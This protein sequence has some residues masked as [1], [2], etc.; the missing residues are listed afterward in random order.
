MLLKKHFWLLSML[1]TVNIFMKPW[2]ILFF[3]IHR[4]IESSKEQRLFEIEIFCNIINVFT[5][6]FDHFNASLLN[7]SIN[8][9][10]TPNIQTYVYTVYCDCND[11]CDDVFPQGRPGIIGHK[12][13]KGDSVGLPVSFSHVSPKKYYYYFIRKK[14]AFLL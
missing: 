6:T 11:V 5:G 13:E 1:K 7:K 4:W 2:Y 12:G 9:F 10:N 8:F 3:R 14:W